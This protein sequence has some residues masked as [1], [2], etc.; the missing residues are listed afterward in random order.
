MTSYRTNAESETQLLLPRIWYFSTFVVA[1]TGAILGLIETFSSAEFGQNPLFSLGNYI[2]Y[3]TNIN[4]WL[5]VII[6]A[7]L[8]LHPMR[9]GG[10]L[11]PSLRLFSV[12]SATVVWFIQNFILNYV[13]GHQPPQ[14][15]GVISDPAVHIIGPLMVMLGWLLFSSRRLNRLANVP[16]LLIIPIIYLAYTVWRGITINWFPYPIVDADVLGW[17]QTVLNIA[18]VGLL[19]LIL[20]YIYFFFDQVLS[21]FK[22]KSIN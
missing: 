11:W 13:P 20:G 22:R 3:F 14:G 1:L 8:T 10:R 19:F 7:M 6:S 15:L 9:K 17:P 5:M 2:G 12:V 21:R 18:L 4:A 16:A